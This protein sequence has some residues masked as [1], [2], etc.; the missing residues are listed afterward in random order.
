MNPYDI[1]EPTH[2]EKLAEISKSVKQEMNEKK[3]HDLTRDPENHTGHKIL[4]D[5]YG[6]SVPNS[7]KYGRA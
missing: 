6:M 7:F 5:K 2:T 1:P 3:F 4:L